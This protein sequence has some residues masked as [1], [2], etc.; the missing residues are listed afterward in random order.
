CSCS[1]DEHIQLLALIFDILSSHHVVINLEKCRF[2]QSSIKYIGHIVG[3]GQHMPDPEKLSAI[4]E[5][6]RPSTKSEL[7]SVLGLCGYYRDYIPHFAEIA[8]PLTSLTAKR[9]PNNIPWSEAAESAFVK[10]KD[11]L[12]HATTLFTPEIGKPFYICTDASAFAAGAC[13]AQR[14]DENKEQPIAFASKKFSDSEKNWS[15]IEREA[16][17]VIWA[18]KPFDTWIFGSKI[19]IISDHNPLSYL[20]NSAP[21]NAKLVRW[22]LALQRYDIELQHRSVAKHANADALSRLGNANWD[23]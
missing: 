6:K 20:T 23:N 9:F 22:A 2:A 10:L 17:A 3:S 1:W 4:R 5:L 14:N 21:N 11:A 19:Y 18:L 7:R 16:F 12:Q 15:T 8:Q 13:L